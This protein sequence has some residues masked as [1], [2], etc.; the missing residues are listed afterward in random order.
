MGE[1]EINKYL[2][3]LA[4]DRSVSA[5]TQNQARN[6]ILFLYLKALKQNIGKPEDF[7][8]AKR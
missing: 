4:V 6:A 8:I 1:K 2:T 3:H 7:V 5:S